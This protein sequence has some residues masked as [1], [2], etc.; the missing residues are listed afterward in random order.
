M[1]LDTGTSR[2][3]INERFVRLLNVP[4]EP[5]QESDPSRLSVADSRIIP[6]IGKV[7]LTI[8]ISGLS[9]PFVF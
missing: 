9:L 7:L 2:S 4:I 8:K 1:L 5:L 6:V 3:V